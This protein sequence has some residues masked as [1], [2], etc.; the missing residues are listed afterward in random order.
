MTT[1]GDV[2]IGG[3]S[4]TRTRLGIGTA[5]QLLRTNSGATAPEWASTLSG[6]TL[7]AP[8][9]S[10]I[11]NT[12]TI[13][14]PTSTDTL[15]GKATTD[16]L[17]NKTLTS[18]AI[19]PP[20]NKFTDVTKVTGD[21]PYS[22]ATTDDIIRADASSGA[23]TVTLP[24]AVGVTGKTYTIRRID[25]L[26]SSVMVTVATTSSQT[27]GGASAEY[28]TP[29]DCIV[30]ESDNANWQVIAR[31]PGLCNMQKGST[32]NRRYVAGFPPGCSITLLTT[33]TLPAL[34]TLW[35]L[36]IIVEKTTKFDT[37]SFR[38]TTVASA[39]GVAMMGIYRDTGNC[40]PGALIFDSGSIDTT[41][42]TLKDVTIT[43]GLQVLPAGLYWL[44]WQARVA[45]P[46][47]KGLAGQTGTIGLLNPIGS[48]VLGTN[49]SEYGYSVAN[50]S[51]S[52]PDPY[53]AAAT[54]LTTAPAVGVPVPAI[55]L[56]PI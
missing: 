7:T 14:L 16:T 52:L 51:N 18:P 6:L 31:T 33:T 30:V 22:I 44:A 4:G 26:A 40:Y 55:G 17:T 20:I 41:T 29:G 15:V 36:P 53:T 12:G 43:S 5:N 8:V 54:G 46:Q 2:I 25:I 42:G 45:A 39:G 56:R 37:I 50:A 10:T 3:A 27:I 32:A 23:L 11:S 9:I 35:A 28:L 38:I 24:T 13:T 1:A 49:L 19:N 21:S 47:I 34:D 48:A